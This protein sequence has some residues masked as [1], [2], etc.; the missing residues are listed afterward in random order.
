MI[1]S[2]DDVESPRLRVDVCV[3]GAGAAGIT[4]ARELDGAAL[5]V[6]VLESGWRSFDPTTQALY[7]TDIVGLAHGGVHDLRFRM[8]GGSTTRWAGQALPLFDID[9]EQRDWIPLSGWPLNRSDLDSYYRRAAELM[10]IPPFPSDGGDWPDALAPPPAFDRRL[11]TPVYSEFSPAPNFA[12]AFGSTLDA[13][14]NIEILLGANA[15]ELVA[16][17]GATT[18][19]LVR[20]RSFDGTEIEVDARY[21]VICCGGIET[22]RLLLVSGVGNEHDLVGRFFMDHPGFLV[23][24][25]HPLGRRLASM[26]KPVRVHGVKFVPRFA[27]SPALQREE[28]LLNSVGGIQFEP[29]QS[30]SITAGKLIARS[31]RQREL[32]RAVP[33]ALAS[34]IRRPLPLLAAAGRHFLLRRPALDTSGIP[35]LGVGCE[36]A[37]NPKSRVLLLD[38]RDALGVRRLALDWRLTEQEIRTCRR[39]AE[40]AANE[41][42]R[43]DL[44]E[45]DLDSFAL[46]DYPD[47]L[48]GLVLDAGHHMGTT[49][50]ATERTSGVVDADCRVFGIENLYVGSCS[51]FPTSGFSNP[52]FTL[53]ALCLRLADTL[54]KRAKVGA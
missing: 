27:T 12:S 51:V 43:L 23:A 10:R 8:F 5:R 4:I 21:F 19:D 25:V 34:V 33:S 24:P 13:S 32:R 11:L 54:R 1:R 44:G 47:E 40:V 14:R 46:P 36:Q 18:V 49:R 22:A 53:I 7:R 37:P 41:L 9:F 31:L 30:E 29:A 52:T 15:I 6:L 50:M 39:V 45:V 38:D 48:S 35:T 2:L 26:F 3:I 28:R 17:S 42:S 16:D 20:A